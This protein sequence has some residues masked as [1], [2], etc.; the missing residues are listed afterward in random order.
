MHRFLNENSLGA[1]SPSGTVPPGSATLAS[2]AGSDASDPVKGL[3]DIEKIGLT[4]PVEQGVDDAQL[5]VAVGH[6]PASVWPGDTGN[7][8]LEA[9]D[10]SWFVNISKLEQGDTIRYVTP[11][12]TYTFAVQAHS[13]V[14]QGTAVYNTTTP[15]LTLVT[16]WP[17]N[18]LWFTPQRYLVTANLVS[19][20]LTRQAGTS[21][22]SSQPAPTVPVP[23]ALAALGVTLTTY[24]LPMG[25]MALAGTPDQAWSQSTNPLLVESS[26]VK[27]YIAGVRALTQNRL[28]WWSALAPGVTPPKPLVGAHNPSYLTPLNVTITAVG[29]QATSVSLTNTVN[30]VG[31][32]TPGRYVVQVEETITDGR[33]LITGWSLS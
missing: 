32:A 9:H 4:A 13:V 6:V 21:Y 28:D 30:I 1:P 22:V 18:A 33:L 5:D 12:I 10:V 31:G 24:S 15:T 25:Q 23:P 7:A 11:C 17:T 2:C 26:A 29:M 16:C 14:E 20:A 3:L 27:A 19:S 8:V